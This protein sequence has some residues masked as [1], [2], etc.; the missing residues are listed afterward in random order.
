MNKNY[1]ILFCILIF[2]FLLRF[3]NVGLIPPGLNRDEAA[4]GYNA[5]SLLL[6]GKDEYG[7]NYPLSLKS[8]GDWKLPLYVYTD[9]PFIKLLSLNELSVRFPSLFFGTLT[10]LLVYLTCRKIFELHP[11]RSRVSLLAAIFLAFSPWHVHFSRV[12]SEANL[13]AFFVMLG[14]LFFLNGLNNFRNIILSS[15]FLALSLYTYH[16]SHIFTLLFFIGLVIILLKKHISK[17]AVLLFIIPFILLGSVIYSLTLVSAD[18]TKISGLTPLSD[19]YLVYENTV[20]RR[21]DYENPGSL[22]SRVFQNK[23]VYL[24]SQVMVN[25]LRG[26][27]VD[28]LFVSGGGNLQHNIPGFGNFYIWDSFFLVAGI[29][30][31]LKTKHPWRYLLLYWLLVSPLPASITK[32]A[33]HSARMFALLPLPQILMGF[34]FIEVFNLFKNIKWRN[35]AGSLILLVLIINFSVFMNKYFIHFPK[36]SEVAWGNGYKKLVTQVNAV[37]SNYWEIIMDKPDYSPYIYFLFYN[38]FNPAIFQE[39]VNRYSQTSE[40][41]QH[42]LGIDKYIFRK[43][44]WGSDE[45]HLPGTLLISFPNDTPPSATNSSYFVDE[46]FIERIQSKYNNSFNLER[47]DFI[48]NK[49]VDKVTLDNGQD[50]L[51]LIGLERVPKIIGSEK[52]I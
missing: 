14:L 35:L 19:Q 16:G 15:C 33:P 29:Y 13:S 20:L 30:Y 10:V 36:I 18:K 34:G 28:F 2:A 44:D 4:I 49:I 26:F 40:G 9:I 37:K 32:D 11:S 21:L 45:A 43:L 52:N 1:F 41:F 22:V 6:T 12:T 42:V 25:Y 8:F 39:K 47:G 24:V 50:F 46:N 27:S 5:Y 17:K 38:H 51:Y 3:W 31:I 7:A 23:Y 48:K